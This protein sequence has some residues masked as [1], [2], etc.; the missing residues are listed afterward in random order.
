MV[1]AAFVSFVELGVLP[2][3][4]VVLILSR[5]FAVTGLRLLAASKGKVISAGKWGKHKT[6]WQIV[7]ISAL[8]MGLAI[9][10]D[11][12]KVISNS[13]RTVADY[14]FAFGYISFAIGVAVVLITLASGAMYF[15]DHKD[16]IRLHIR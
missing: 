11:L 14:N 6:V 2:A 9:R 15:H 8:L 13:A 7:G 10:D 12:L 5:E 3:W 4:M 16:M 1:C